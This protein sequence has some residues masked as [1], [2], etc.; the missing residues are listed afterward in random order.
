M[1]D[2]NK[3]NDQDYGNNVYEAEYKTTISDSNTNSQQQDNQS[4][5]QFEGTVEKD[6]SKNSGT[7]EKMD[8]FDPQEIVKKSRK[9]L[10]KLNQQGYKIT[11]KFS[12]SQDSELLSEASG[13]LTKILQNIK[14]QNQKKGFLGKVKNSLPNFLKNG[15][16]KAE[17]HITETKIS[18]QSVGKTTHDI[19]ENLEGHQVS[20]TEQVENICDMKDGIYQL[21]MGLGEQQQELEEKYNYLAENGYFEHDSRSK[22]NME[23]LIG[24]VKT[25]IEVFKNQH[26]N[27]HKAQ[28]ITENFLTQLD[29]QMPKIK[30]SLINGLTTM[31]FLNEVGQLNENFNNLCTTMGEIDIGNSEKIRDMITEITDVTRYEEAELERINKHHQIQEETRKNVQNNQQKAIAFNNKKQQTL[32]LIDEDNKKHR[33]DYFSSDLTDKF[34]YPELK[35]KGLTSKE[36]KKEAN[37]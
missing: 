12:E 9:N 2:S 21:V 20:I 28:I 19:F 16:S 13:A 30:T 23:K 3:Q 24:Q 26:D 36:E 7:F 6:G 22:F 29:D 27:I 25:H 33:D 1:V 32:R 31:S 5:Q 34:S 15:I 8:D 37:S 10:D 17:S 11:E 4:S 14:A 35:T 18:N